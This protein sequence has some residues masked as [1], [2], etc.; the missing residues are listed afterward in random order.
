MEA[1][2]KPKYPLNDFQNLFESDPGLALEIGF[3]PSL[4]WNNKDGLYGH[5]DYIKEIQN[6]S[7]EIIEFCK[8]L[9]S[10]EIEQFVSLLMGEEMAYQ[11]AQFQIYKR[12]GFLAAHNDISHD[13]TLTFYLTPRW[14]PSWGGLLEFS[15]N[16]G[17]WGAI[18]IPRLGS[19]SFC[20]ARQD[21]K[22]RVTTVSSKARMPRISAVVRFK[23]K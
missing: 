15:Y 1:A 14:I 19:V 11:G 2:T 20:E 8:T 21:W 3:M 18:A 16:K 6:P 9:S 7:S 12:D 22:H 17:P 5:F 4:P 10:D 23:K 13:A